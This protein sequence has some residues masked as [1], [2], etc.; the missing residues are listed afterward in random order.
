MAILRTALGSVLP[1]G[2]PNTEAAW[3]E[4]LKP[5]RNAVKRRT[6]YL[7]L[8]QR[9]AL[10]AAVGP[11]AQPFVTALCLLPLRPGAVAA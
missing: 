4:A 5:I 3:Q 2:A 7:T 9:R 10:V 11:E 8:E 6:L 1:L